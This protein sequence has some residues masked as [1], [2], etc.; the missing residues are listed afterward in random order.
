M[1]LYC[2]K[3]AQTFAIDFLLKTESEWPGEKF[4]YNL[5]FLKNKSSNSVRKA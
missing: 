4:D 2:D 3:L 1:K 5:E